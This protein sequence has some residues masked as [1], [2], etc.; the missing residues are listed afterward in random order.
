MGSSCSKI[1]PKPEWN[2]KQTFL[3]DNRKNKYAII[4]D[5]RGERVVLNTDANAA[6]GDSTS[7]G[8]GVVKIPMPQEQ[9]RVEVR[10]F[11]Y[12]HKR[13]RYATGYI[14]T[15]DKNIWMVEVNV[16]IFF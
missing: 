9:L 2:V 15:V 13:G 11:G 6:I 12:S 8:G 10:D 3:I 7:I 14:Y 16:E 1:K 5:E 4:N